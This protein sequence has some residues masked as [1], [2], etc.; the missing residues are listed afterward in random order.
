[1][2]VAAARGVERFTDALQS[3]G[4]SFEVVSAGWDA[5]PALVARLY[6]AIRRSRSDIVHTHLIHADLHGQLAARLARVRGVISVH[7]TH[8]FYLREPVHTAMRL[9]A[10]SASRT[11]AI[12]EHAQRFLVEAGIVQR[13]RVRVVHYGI[14]MV[15]WHVSNESRASARSEL[16]IAPDET[17][18]GIAARLI[19]TKGHDILIEAF[20]AASSQIPGLKLLVA[21][22]GPL[23]GTL[24]QMARETLQPASAEFLGHVHNMPEFMAACDIL[25]FPSSSEGFGL[26]VLEAM[27]A[28]IP[29]VASRAASLPEI[30]ADGET[31]RLVQPSRPD[32]LAEVI[33]ELA[34]DPRLRQT[35]GAAG[36]ERARLHFSLDKMADR[37]IAVY[38]EADSQR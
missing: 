22:D 9:A 29:V 20:A 18:V 19:P 3:A 24:E 33:T 5:S 37:T 14:S 34:R 25:A 30:V 7:G 1:M 23:R 21:G 26:A 36:R 32:E 4:I 6:R 11:I 16:G 31:G 15:P 8:S 17:T 27:A 10:R 12:S 38:S 28:G 35:F 2:L 13:E